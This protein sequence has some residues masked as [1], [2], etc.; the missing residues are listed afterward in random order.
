[1]LPP[2]LPSSFE[3]SDGQVRYYVK[4]DIVRDWKWNHKVKQHFMVNGILD[5][6]QFPSAMQ[7]GHE[8]DHKRLCCLCC[9][10]GPISA[11]ITTN[12]AGY[13]PGEFI[14]F[15]AEVDN[16]SNRKMNGS[17]LN[18]VETV[19]YKAHTKIKREQR[20]VSEIRRGR[21]LPGTSDY[22]DGV[23]MRVP[24]VPPTNLAGRCGI[25]DVQ[26]TLEFHV[27]PSGPAFDLVVRLPIIIGTIPLRQYINTFAPPPVTLENP[28]AY[29]DIGGDVIKVASDTAPSAPP[30]PDQFT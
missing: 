6:N 19:T 28:P 30:P 2:N 13:V 17:F 26:Y 24:A 11:V 29:E 5:L 12:R 22:W 7:Q 9:K 8:R 10:S 15:S 16:L 25:M 1:M 4:A 3:S 23:N 20:V 18:L 21:I 14:G 27:D